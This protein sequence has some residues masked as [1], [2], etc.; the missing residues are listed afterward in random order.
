MIRCNMVTM[1]CTEDR[2]DLFLVYPF[3]CVQST[4]YDEK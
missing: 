2:I 1:Y 3:G 4:C